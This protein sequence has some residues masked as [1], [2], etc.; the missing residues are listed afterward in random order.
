MR[1][2]SPTI[3]VW[4]T[5][6]SSTIPKCSNW[7]G[8][9]CCLAIRRWETVVHGQSFPLWYRIKPIGPVGRPLW[10]VHS[11]PL[12]PLSSE[13]QFFFRWEQDNKQTNVSGAVGYHDNAEISFAFRNFWWQAHGDYLHLLQRLPRHLPQLLWRTHGLT[14]F[15]IIQV[16]S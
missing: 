7:R 3:L 14:R 9:C 6:E 8:V 2:E 4:Q 5:P 11:S 12:F 13:P 15:V 1:S 16:Y 10:N